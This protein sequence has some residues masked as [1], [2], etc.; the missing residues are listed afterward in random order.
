MEEE[1]SAGTSASIARCNIC[2][3]LNRNVSVICEGRCLI[4]IRCQLT[5]T[6][7]KLFVSSPVDCPL[8]DHPMSRTMIRQVHSFGSL[9]SLSNVSNSFDLEAVSSPYGAFLKR[10]RSTYPATLTETGQGYGYQ[11]SDKELKEL[12][13]VSAAGPNLGGAA[14]TT[15]GDNLFMTAVGGGGAEERPLSSPMGSRPGTASEGDRGVATAKG[16]K[17]GAEEDGGLRREEGAVTAPKMTMNELLD[18]ALECYGLMWGVIA[19]QGNEGMCA[20]T[21]RFCSKKRLSQRS[22]DFKMKS[23]LDFFF[24]NRQGK[25][26]PES[27]PHAVLFGK[28]V[29]LLPRRRSVVRKAWGAVGLA[30]LAFAYVEKCWKSSELVDSESNP[31]PADVKTKLNKL[32]SNKQL[33][34]KRVLQIVGK[35]NESN[36]AHWTMAPFKAACEE[37]NARQPWARDSQSRL[38]HMI[39]YTALWVNGRIKEVT[40]GTGSSLTVVLATGGIDPLDEKLR[41]HL[42]PTN[43]AANGATSHPQAA[44]LR[45]EH[46]GLHKGAFNKDK[47]KDR[48][49]GGKDEITSVVGIKL[50]KALTAKA[51]QLWGA[52]IH[53]LPTAPTLADVMR[54]SEQGTVAEITPEMAAELCGRMTIGICEAAL[55]LIDSW[56]AE[57]MAFQTDM[58]KAL[59]STSR[60]PAIAGSYDSRH[61]ELNRVERL[62]V[63]RLLK[64]HNEQDHLGV[65][66]TSIKGDYDE[67]R[68]LEYPFVVPASLLEKTVAELNYHAVRVIAQYEKD[69]AKEFIEDLVA[70]SGPY[71]KTP[72]QPSRPPRSPNSRPGRAGA[73]SRGEADPIYTL[74]ASQ[75]KAVHRAEYLAGQ[76]LGID[77][78]TKSAMPGRSRPNSAYVPLPLP[79]S[80][81]DDQSF[82]TQ[83]QTVQSDALDELSS[84]V[85]LTGISDPRPS[86]HAYV[87]E[88]QHLSRPE[89]PED[90]QSREMLL[91][92]RDLALSAGEQ[93]ERAGQSRPTSSAEAL[94]FVPP[95]QSRA[96]APVQQPL[97]TV[98]YASP[99]PARHVVSMVD[100]LDNDAS[101][102]AKVRLLSAVPVGPST[103]KSRLRSLDEDLFGSLEEEMSFEDSTENHQVMRATPTTTTATKA[104]GTS[105]ATSVVDSGKQALL[106]QMTAKQRVWAQAEERRKALQAKEDKMRSGRIE[107]RARRAAEEPLLH[108]EVDPAASL[109]RVDLKSALGLGR[110]AKKGSSEPPGPA[111][112][113]E[114]KLASEQT[115]QMLLLTDMTAE[116]AV[117]PDVWIA[118]TDSYLKPFQMQTLLKMDFTRACMG[119]LGGTVLAKALRVHCR[120]LDLRLG[121]NEVGDTACGKIIASIAAGGGGSTLLALDL[122]GNN[123]TMIGDGLGGLSQLSALQLLDLSHNKVTLDLAR[124]HETLR[125]AISSLPALAGLSLAQNRI[126]DAGLSTLTAVLLHPTQGLPSLRFLDLK[127]CFISPKSF[128]LLEHLIKE[129]S[130]NS[131]EW[132]PEGIQLQENILTNEQMKEISYVA[133][134][135]DM[136]V[137]FRGESKD[138]WETI[139]VPYQQLM[140][141]APPVVH[142]E[143]GSIEVT[144]SISAGGPGESDEQDRVSGGD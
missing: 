44:A 37:Y 92:A 111:Q 29:G 30:V 122:S 96:R 143:M 82:V 28:I 21:Q 67:G 49:D 26:G 86:L 116:A 99:L 136:P 25:D 113:V 120:L 130:I 90:F 65:D 126:Q 64:Y 43:G 134:V 135:R 68:P 38:M 125:R 9:A 63:I 141:G 142:L 32:Q 81:D 7:R 110:R 14:T 73:L 88:Q 61:A 107:A 72:L 8:C 83:V 6:I 48:D 85:N 59:V 131:R 53:I 97:S 11:L 46:S 34:L 128:A 1:K 20:M 55:A 2:S 5:P 27:S 77:V 13:S 100:V 79:F 106:E 114:S 127:K 132:A 94:A 91:N 15:G 115:V 54:F 24:E 23:F 112:S 45:R 47:D 124:H 40:T 22:N 31:P 41:H 17:K 75:I 69:K 3:T 36:Q 109:T 139:K 70:A 87:T 78:P 76:V 60:R 56:E 121:G 101:V 39:I 138:M 102:L 123:L 10:Y 52:R 119:A 66:W 133:A 58:R 140:P 89:S 84:S 98:P 62:A 74:D 129:P 105:S 118:I 117:G 33:P 57:Y 4:C 137:V 35:L 93:P 104:T 12:E 16:G 103:S 95:G 71:A 42:A 18:F 144:E 108:R 51:S 80:H 19:R 50:L